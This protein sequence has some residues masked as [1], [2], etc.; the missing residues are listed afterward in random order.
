MDGDVVDAEILDHALP[1]AGIDGKLGQGNGGG[2]GPPGVGGD[3]GGV[4]AGPRSR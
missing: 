2:L 1:A 4:A 3:E